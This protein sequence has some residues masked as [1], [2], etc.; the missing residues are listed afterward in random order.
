MCQYAKICL[1]GVQN[2]AFKFFFK[3]LAYLLNFMFRLYSR[4]V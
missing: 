4:A 3:F 1:T 2:F